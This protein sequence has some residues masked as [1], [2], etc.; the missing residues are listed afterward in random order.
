MTVA[1]EWNNKLKKKTASR[2]QDMTEDFTFTWAFYFNY[3]HF[4]IKV[5]TDNM[6]E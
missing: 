4:N 1:S 3:K 5:K 6:G 2:E